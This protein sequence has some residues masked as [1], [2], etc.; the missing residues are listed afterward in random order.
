VK[1]WDTENKKNL[2]S[3]ND[4]TGI[5]YDVKFHPDGTCVCS[6]SHDKK[7]KVSLLK[8]KKNKLAPCLLFS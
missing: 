3:F 2:Q 4:H 8:K 6:A 5:I 7:I 1:I